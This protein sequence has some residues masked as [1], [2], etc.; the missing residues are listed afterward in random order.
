MKLD[1]VRREIRAEYGERTIDRD[2]WRFTKYGIM[3]SAVEDMQSNRSIVSADLRAKAFTSEGQAVKMPVFNNEA[4]SLKSVRSCTIDALDNTTG[5]VDLVWITIVADIDM[6]KGQFLNQGD[7]NGV[8]PSWER[9]YAISLNKKLERVAHGIS[10][11]IEDTLYAFLD[12]GKSDYFKSTLVTGGTYP[13]VGGAVQVTPAQRDHFFNDLSVIMMEDDFD[14][15]YKVLGSTST[16]SIVNRYINQGSA[17]AT[18]TQYQFNDYMF[19][20]S[21]HLPNGQN[22]FATMFVMPEGSVG[23]LP[24]VTAD[25]MMENEAGDGTKWYQDDLGMWGLPAEIPV[26][27]QF[28]S[29]CADVSTAVSN[30][31]LTASLQEFWQISV[32]VAYVIPY[33][34]TPLTKSGSIKKFEFT[35]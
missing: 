22:V 4:I 12:A 30:P 15:M 29:Q 26:S 5:L 3:N 13:V 19:R 28:K 23:I 1:T 18:N 20:Y 31:A 33:N 7:P 17:N 35:T 6:K 16:M 8:F 2:E 11:E 27:V 34:S 14:P 24:R 32:D 25:A 10:Q 21:N 9:A